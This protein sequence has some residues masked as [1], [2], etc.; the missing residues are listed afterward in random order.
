MTRD[1]VD[2]VQGPPKDCVVG[3]IDDD[4]VNVALLEAMLARAGYTGLT[5]SSAA[6]FR[7]RSGPGSVDLILLDWDMPGESGLDFLRL[8]REQEQ[9]TTPVIFV[10]QYDRDEQIAQGLNAGADDY[11][12]KPVEATVLVARIESVLRR[13]NRKGEI[14]ERWPPF[15]FD[16]SQRSL[17]IDGKSRHATNREFELMLFMFRRHGRVVTRESLLTHV[18][19]LSSNVATRSIDTHISRLRKL[20]GLDGSSGWRLEGVYQK[21]YCLKRVEG[22]EASPDPDA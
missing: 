5:F 14:V 19:R 17:R 16:V 11:M 10:T 13:L 3:V 20:F 4:P 7:R 2:S 18:W 9:M 6:D 8:M 15:E 21:G 1:Q 22:P 12:T